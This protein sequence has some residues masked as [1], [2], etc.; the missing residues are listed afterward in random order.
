VQWLQPMSLQLNQTQTKVYATSLHKL[1][2]WPIRPNNFLQGRVRHQHILRTG[3]VWTNL[4][5]IKVDP[6][7]IL[8]YGPTTKVVRICSGPALNPIVIKH[9]VIAFL[10]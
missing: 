10:Y 1:R 3:S 4:I 6:E 9:S 7:A 8:S 5:G 2:H